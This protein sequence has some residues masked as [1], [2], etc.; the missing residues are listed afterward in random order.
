M[1]VALLKLNFIFLFIN[2]FIFTPSFFLDC[3]VQ[4]AW[5][6]NVK[7]SENRIDSNEYINNC[8]PKSWQPFFK[9]LKKIYYDG[10]DISLLRK[11]AD[12]LMNIGKKLDN[13]IEPQMP[14]LFKALELVD[15]ED[16]KVVILGQD[17]TPQKQK[18]TGVAFH[19]EKPRFVPAVLH[20]FL[21]VAFEGFPVDL[22]N[23]D[24]TNWARQGVLLLNTALTC[25]HDKANHKNHFDIWRDFTVNLIGHICD[26]ADLSVWLLWGATAKSFSKHIKGKYLIIRGGHPSPMGTAMHG[27]SFF[28]NNYFNIANQFLEINDRVA[29]DWSLSGTG[30]NGLEFGLCRQTENE[31]KQRQTEEKQLRNRQQQK[32]NLINLNE[33]EIKNIQQKLEKT[34]REL[35]KTERDLNRNRWLQ[36]PPGIIYFKNKQKK[37]EEKYDEELKYLNQLHRKIK[38]LKNQQ[39]RIEEKIQQNRKNQQ[40]LIGLPKDLL[41]RNFQKQINVIDEELNQLRWKLQ[42]KQLHCQ[43]IS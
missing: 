21:E 42:Q 24:V 2:L 33:R 15:P 41:K 13:A 3:L 27:D 11:L 1:Y 6:D 36:N 40:Y 31:V 19:V 12:N 9:R 4:S 39:S 34:N 38:G 23:G 10:T 25:P 22:N 20:M 26:S 30:Q 28:G 8:L 35:L 29:I 32:Q 5:C 18:A 43:I 7:Y 17:P 14:L 37:L 16:V